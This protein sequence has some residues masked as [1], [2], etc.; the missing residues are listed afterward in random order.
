M[1]HCRLLRHL[2]LLLI[3]LF[4][5][6]ACKSGEE[7]TVL[8]NTAGP[9]ANSNYSGPPPATDDV[10]NFKR[11][12]WDNLVSNDRCGGCHSTGG[13]SPMFV[14][15]GDI[16]VAYAAANTVVNLTDP[17]QSRM[18]T[19]VAGGHNCWLSSDQAC[20]DTLTRYIAEWSGNSAGAAK[21][22]DLT[23][24]TIKEP[25][26]TKSFPVDPTRFGDTVYLVLRNHCADCHVE[27]IQTPYFASAD[28]DT[29]YSAAQSRINLETPGD[30]RLVQRL[31]NDFHNCW[32][33]D[34][35]ADAQ[36]MADVIA[37]FAGDLSP[38]EVNPD[39]VTSKAL[40]LLQDGLA[41]NA[42]GRF[43]DNIIALY[44]FKSGSGY[45]AFDTSGVEPAL[46][47]NLTGNVEWVQ[48]WG[49]TIGAGYDDD[50][51]ARVANGK[52]QGSTAV[53]RKLY[54]SLTGSGEFSIETWI[55]PANT[56]QED[57]R[58]VTYSG[59]STARNVTLSQTQQ[60]YQVLQRSSTTDQNTPFSTADGDQVLQA[61]LQHVVVNFTPGRG[62]EIFVNGES[63]GDV[64]PDNAGLLNEWDDS[65]ALVLGNE[66]DSNSL[67]QGTL[68]MVAIHNRALT[69]AQIKT[70]FEVGVGQK[71]YLLFNV[72]E[73]SKIPESYVVF[74]VSQFDSYSYLF[75]EPFFIS[76]D[77][78]Q[79]PGSIPVKGMRIG[80]N[81]KEATVGQSFANLDI[82]L[83]DS[84]YQPGVGQS[85]SPLGT[86]IGAENGPEVDEF[87]LTFDV[88]GD[89]SHAR[90]EPSVPTPSTPDPVV[91]ESDLGLKTFDEINAS[92]SVMTGIPKT[93]SGVQQTFNTVRQQLPSVETIK[94]FLSS[95]QMA[96]TQMAIQYCNALVNDT[97]KRDTLFPDVNFTAD[98]TTAFGDASGRNHVIDPLLT[99]FVGTG[100][101]SQPDEADMRTELDS[102]MQ[103]LSSCSGTCDAERTAT[104]VKAT[105]AA[106]LGSAV[107]LVQ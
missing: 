86:V 103:S 70:N 33:D 85:M 54:D 58:I 84:D 51:G 17:G 32:S 55:V 97:D 39:F 80:I 28:L 8:P 50:S 18:V 26:Q 96:I 41:A 43:E 91:P 14:H 56:T 101:T 94:G 59:S 10:Q 71:Y 69:P 95:Q 66:T 29:A 74:E 104:V 52:A 42:G 40:S 23:A 7:T 76:L 68:R 38:T 36:F 4:A 21:K 45:T 5:L 100:L 106:V 15:D 31:G 89:Q 107:T 46:Q 2:P 105:C 27:G 3:A 90:T 73:L 44:E 102:L 63:T 93:A 57:A 9:G 75:S 99:Q 47:L 65:F 64:D 82:V 37:E 11:A 92:M 79:T 62:R 61:S 25:G 22:I 16:N 67:W 24:P 49:I 13:Q 6:S 48:G 78:S 60:N 83:S 1:N 30:S 88:F 53:S 98:P 19:K 81:G 35:A 34:C 87:F 77:D 72:V 20:A 12:V